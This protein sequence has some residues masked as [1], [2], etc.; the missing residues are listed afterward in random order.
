MRYTTISGAIIISPHVFRIADVY[1]V[2]A[3]IAAVLKVRLRGILT[4]LGIKYGPV[5]VVNRLT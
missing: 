5:S 2:D 4:I 3:C 1:M